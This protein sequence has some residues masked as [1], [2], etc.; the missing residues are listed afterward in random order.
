MNKVN[1][2]EQLVECGLCVDNEYLDRYVD[3]I[4]D[5]FNT[6]NVTKKTQQHHIRPR[7]YYKHTHQ[8]LDNSKQNLVNLLYKDHVLAHYYLF[9]CS[10]DNSLYQYCNSVSIAI[11]FGHDNFPKSELDI[12]EQLDD[13]QQ[14]YEKSRELSSNF[15]VMFDNVVKSKHDEKMRSEDVRSRISNTVKGKIANGEFFDEEHRKNLSAARI[16]IKHLNKDGVEVR[17]KDPLKIQQLLESGWSFGGV[18]CDPDVVKRR[19]AKRCLSVSCID[20][21]GTILHTFGSLKEACNW[22]Y[23]SGLYTRKL[24]NIPYRLADSIKDSSKN[25]R[26]I[27]G[28]KWIYN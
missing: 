25:N 9:K 21:S 8:R 5:N 28:L 12:L 23:N 26:F 1:L 13:Y 20:E 27:C 15:N 22:W 19:A 7:Y 14:F 17:T 16:G 3:L 10:P 4:C 11:I 24:P 6:P 18:S 2:R